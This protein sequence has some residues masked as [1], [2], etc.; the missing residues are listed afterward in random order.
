MHRFVQTGLKYVVHIGLAFSLV[1]PAP[2]FTHRMITDSRWT[3]EHLEA[4]CVIVFNDE[5]E[6]AVFSYQLRSSGEHMI[7]FRPPAWE[8]GD[9]KTDQS[10]VVIKFGENAIIAPGNIDPLVGRAISR[11]E[12]LTPSDFQLFQ[13]HES[14]EVTMDKYK[15]LV[16]TEGVDT[17]RSEFADCLKNLAKAGTPPELKSWKLGD[18][19]FAAVQKAISLPNSKELVIRVDAGGKP[20]TCRSIPDASRSRTMQKACKL[21]LGIEE[22]VPATDPQGNPTEGDYVVFRMK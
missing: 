12:I 13:K 16:P 15:M 18:E 3:V 2:S 19:V 9:S 21:Y 17:I 8:P 22:Y 10:G 6:D 5:T 14:F 4:D 11:G 1:L 7:G 20:T